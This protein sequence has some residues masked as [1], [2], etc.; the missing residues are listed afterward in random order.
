MGHIC[1]GHPS[2]LPGLAIYE[3]DSPQRR[4]LHMIGLAVQRLKETCIF[5]ID[6]IHDGMDQVQLALI[7]FRL[8]AD[9]VP[10]QPYW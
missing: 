7:G 8:S 9:L 5:L 4:R 1:C 3:L 2:Y 6:R 10:R